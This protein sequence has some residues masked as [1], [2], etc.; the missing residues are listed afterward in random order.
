MKIAVQE[1]SYRKEKE[2]GDISILCL[3][4]RWIEFT[5]ICVEKKSFSKSFWL[6]MHL[7]VLN[8]RSQ[9]HSS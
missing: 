5:N 6:L 9:Y 2:I 7:Y 8:T 4:I 1:K 3:Q